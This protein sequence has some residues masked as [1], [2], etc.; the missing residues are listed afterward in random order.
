[1]LVP[2]PHAPHS[3]LPPLTG[4]SAGCMPKKEADALLACP[5]CGGRQ[6]QK[7]TGFDPLFRMRCDDCGQRS[8]DWKQVDVGDDAVVPGGGSGTQNH[9]KSALT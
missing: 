7:W 3:T 6:P 8:R 4:V 1:M 2:L 9:A 5:K